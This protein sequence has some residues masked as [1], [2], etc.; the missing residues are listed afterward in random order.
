[1]FGALAA[2][3][4]GTAFPAYAAE[5]FGSYTSTSGTPTA[6]SLYFTASDTKNAAGGYDITGMHGD[7]NGELITGVETNP[8]QPFVSLSATKA[9]NFDNV[10]FDNGPLLSSDGV[11]FTTAGGFEYNMWADGGTKYTLASVSETAGANGKY[12]AGP[13]SNGNMTTSTPSAI[14]PPAPPSGQPTLLTFDDARTYAPSVIATQGYQFSGS[15]GCCEFQAASTFVGGG[16]DNG[17]RRITYTL[18]P[19]VMTAVDGS[20][21]SV[22]SLDAGV[23]NYFTA[24]VNYMMD[25]TGTR[26]DGS[27]VTA[28]LAID[29]AFQ[30]F[31]L[32]GFTD[33]VSLKFGHPGGGY[34]M[35]FDN[36]AVGPGSA[37]PEPASWAM[38]FMGLGAMGMT[39]RARRRVAVRIG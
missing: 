13:R 12:P 36:I 1:M 2:C 9:W 24:G 28:S 38:M 6:A 18:V 29:P 25:L 31:A 4:S 17:T 21:F 3:L 16:A 8:H 35:T 14:T 15:G 11:V 34:Y 5:Y 27:Q 22:T 23:G 33:L 39:M 10:L 7:I 37:A 20:A 19:V 30:N 26:A 32:D